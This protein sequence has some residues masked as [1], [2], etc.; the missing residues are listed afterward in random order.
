V[1]DG[2]T[3]LRALDEQDLATRVELLGLP[4]DERWEH[5]YWSGDGVNWRCE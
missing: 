3:R 4:Y 5:P 1:G 2:V